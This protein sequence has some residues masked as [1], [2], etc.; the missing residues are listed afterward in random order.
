MYNRGMFPF[1]KLKNPRRAPMPLWLKLALC[2]FA[3][4]ALTQ[5]KTADYAT[6]L[7]RADET[8]ARLFPGKIMDQDTPKPEST[9]KP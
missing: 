1:P 2:L 4:Y 3:L 6:K 9:P 7:P 8:K 5:L